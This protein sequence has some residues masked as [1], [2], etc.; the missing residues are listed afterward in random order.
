MTYIKTILLSALLL[1]TICSGA[2]I[3]TNK[4]QY[5]S[6]VTVE[7]TPGEYCALVLTPEIYNVAG[8]DLADIRLIGRDGNQIP[9][10][11]GE[12]RGPTET[13][14][15]NPTIL[16]RATDATKT[17]WRRWISAA[18]LSKTQSRSRRQAIISDAR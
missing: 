2:S 8:T 4:W 9:Y 14:K 12:R 16:N 6:E 1:T 11:L 13:V 3:D 5:I 10:V 18:K 15:Y 17:H 7:G